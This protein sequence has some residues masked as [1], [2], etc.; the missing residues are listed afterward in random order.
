VEPDSHRPAD[1]SS[2]PVRPEH[3]VE[4]RNLFFKDTRESE[5]LSL[6]LEK[7]DQIEADLG[8][9]SDVMG[10]VLEDVDLDETIMAAIA[11]DTPTDEVVANIEATIEERKEAL[12]T[13]EE[14]FLIRDRFDLSDED[15]EILDVIERSQHGEVSEDDIEILVREFFDA[16]EGDIKGVRPDLLA[17]VATSIS[18]MFPTCSPATRSS[19]DI[20]WR[21]SPVRSR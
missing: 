15:K 20:R 14:Q 1:G 21:R 18:W 6:L 2:P 12:E 11:N 5:I 7:T 3:T 10:R 17:P 13:V 16:F 9:R 19:S 8:M 4:I